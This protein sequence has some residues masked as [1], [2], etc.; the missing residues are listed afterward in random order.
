M[1]TFGK[2][3]GIRGDLLG[4]LLASLACIAILGLAI[5]GHASA[6]VAL[7]APRDL[8][9]LVIISGAV[10]FIVVAVTLLI[11]GARVAQAGET[12]ALEAVSE[13][14]RQIG[15]AESIL[16]AEPQ[17]LLFWDD[18]QTPTLVSHSLETVPG[19]P[20]DLAVLLRFS[21]WLDMDG[22][23]E[24]KGRL[25]QLFTEGKPFTVFLR[26]KGGGHV[27]AD[28][29]VAGA[30]AILKLRDVAGQKHD[31]ARVV[32]FHR[33]L[34]RDLAAERALFDSLPMPVWLRGEDGRIEWVNAAYVTA[35][36]AE[37]LDH[38]V[39]AQIEFLETKQRKAAELTIVQNQTFKSRVHLIVAGERR[40][41][42]LIVVPVG[43]AS[44]GVAIDVAALETAQG[45]LDRQSAAHDRTL[46]RVST[47]VAVFGSDR[48]LKF[49]NEAYVKLWQLD[50]DWLESHPPDGDVL[51]R[52]RQKRFLPDVS[53]YRDFRN[54]ALARYGSGEAHED[55][56]Y[57]PDGRTVHVMTVPRPDGGITYLYDD[58]TER[59]ALKR[60]F[61][62]LIH[63]QRETIDHLKE[64][65][66]LF[67]TDGKLK[68]FNPAFAR[69]WKLDRRMLGGE[70]HI[71]EIIRQVRVL[72]EGERDWTAIGEAVTG[73]ADRRQPA[74]GQMERADGSVIDYTCLPLPDGATLLTFSDVTDSK[75]IERALTDRNEAL[76]AADRLKSQ[77]IRHVSYELR[78][79]LQS[80]H[81]FAEM[82]TN[83]RLGELNDR[84][85]EY[86]SAVLASSNQLRGI[87]D[88][89]L[90]LAT[91]DAGTLELKTERIDVRSVIAGAQA[92]VADRLQRA[93]VEL[94]VDI[95][96][97][98]L[99]LIADGRRVRQVLSNLLSN[100]IGFSKPGDSVEL[101]CAREGGFVVF[102]LIDHGV[103][104][105]KEQQERVFERFV[106]RT[107]G[108]NH[109]GAGIG[110][111]LIKSLVE[112]HGGTVALTS[113]AGHG[114]KVVVRLP[115]H[116]RRDQAQPRSAIDASA[117]RLVKDTPK[118]R[119]ADDILES[120][121]GQK[122]VLGE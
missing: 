44:A 45:E 58:V 67:A 107:Q 82:L 31:L 72:S 47:A 117:G 50:P 3:I 27:E 32:D 26:T 102:T 93:R 61:E 54:K 120:E 4:L 122:R 73:I 96:P 25:D 34:Q 20:S 105:P 8:L 52:L 118:L 83:P 99:A 10:V 30:R 85:R 1:S 63:V 11:R 39:S 24:I 9:S 12:R 90:D 103:G 28:G 62:L 13:L 91:I 53:N 65:V 18:R 23:Q 115:E 101:N 49:S 33:R 48:T 14:R 86:I 89:I 78:T 7:I 68:L 94:K 112:L 110:L 66:A 97:G 69:I 16:R 5:N 111:P 64:A 59:I 114:T 98:V 113:E 92:E 80:I 57:L 71:E 104:I 22:A 76:V 35:V 43:K 56:W 19:L 29:R 116:G 21:T 95:E 88:S 81:G 17:V 87:I 100:A 55:W 40:A 70:P 74:A 41:F 106:S 109:R 108:S 75:R 6:S 15:A 38:V 36:E 2:R 60:E 84:Q 121:A 37:S 46:D 42:D 77:F 79:P 51:D 119:F